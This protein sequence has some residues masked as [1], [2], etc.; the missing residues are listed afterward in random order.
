METLRLN[1]TKGEK[2]RGVRA[3]FRDFLAAQ[4][5]R[6]H[7]RT[8]ALV[9]HTMHAAVDKLGGEW[10]MKKHYRGAWNVAA[11]YAGFSEPSK[12]GVGSFV[13]FWADQL[14]F[15]A[16]LGAMMSIGRRLPGRL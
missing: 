5:F 10:W 16:A 14:I 1:R 11:H 13:N 6:A 2:F 3:V 8:V 4:E 9:A 15:L 7:A 12:Q